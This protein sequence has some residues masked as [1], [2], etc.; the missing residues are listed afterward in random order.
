MAFGG[1]DRFNGRNLTSAHAK[2]V[3]I[4]LGNENFNAFAGHLLATLN[5][6]GVAENITNEVMT[7]SASTREAVLALPPIE[8]NAQE[9][10]IEFNRD[11]ADGSGEAGSSLGIEEY[12]QMLENMPINVMMAD[13][14]TM[15]IT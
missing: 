8:T 15:N 10:N 12:Q 7:I 1:P 3:N 2:L 9:G 5:E 11:A 14:Q 13:P 4:G 6:L